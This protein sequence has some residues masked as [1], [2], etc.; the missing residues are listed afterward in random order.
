METDPVP[1]VIIS[2]LTQ[3]EAQLTLKALE[4]GAIDY[5]PKPSG[6]ISLNMEV[7]LEIELISKIKN[8]AFANITCC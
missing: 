8:A 1:V 5:V 4:Y 7:L 6:T 3:S 2:A